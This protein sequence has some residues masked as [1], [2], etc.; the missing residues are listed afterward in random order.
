MT[1]QEQ[2][3]QIVSGIQILSKRSYE[4]E[5][6]TKFVRNQMPFS[7]YGGDLKNFGSNQI[8]DSHTERQNL[9]NSLT[10]T[11]YSHYYCGVA[12]DK[13]VYKKPSKSAQQAFMNELSKANASRGGLDYNWK[14][15]SVDPSGNA[16]VQKDGDLRWLQPNSFQYQNPRQQRHQVNTFVHI[17]K[18]RDSRTIQDVFYH[19]FSDEIFPQEVE[20]SRIY[21]NIKPESASKLIR[22]LT[23]TLNSYRIPFQF[24]CLNH[25]DLYVRTD[26]AV[27]YLDKRNVHV[28]SILLKS[29]L[30]E[31]KDDLRE[32]IPM[33]TQKLFK[34]VGFAEDP[35]KGMSFGM[36][37]ST[38]IA[39]AL[40]DAFFSEIENSLEYVLETL[41]QKGFVIERMHLNKHTELIPNF[42][43]YD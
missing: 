35:G 6:Q 5:E 26:A 38:V 7:N 22:L 17:K 19:V 21:W 30:N 2:I 29:I 14:I 3:E 25:P 9:I 33:F 34:G 16:F 1:Y 41:E 43:L 20:L 39:Q 42:P 32:G 37:R 27:L 24:K 15:Y 18:I 28:V 36:S 31:L 40:V 4:V 13:D 10:G 23:T 11:I 8:S 12:N